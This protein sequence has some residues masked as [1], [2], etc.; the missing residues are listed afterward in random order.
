MPEGFYITCECGYE[1]YLPAANVDTEQDCINCGA[2]L[3]TR[4]TS[5][6]LEKDS[7]ALEFIAPLEETGYV[8]PD[9]RR[10]GPRSPFEDDDSLDLPREP[11]V[12]PKETPVPKDSTP[13][14]AASLFED[15][16]DDIEEQ[17]VSHRPDPSLIRNY[18][19]AE[20]KAAYQ[21]NTETDTCPQC[22]NVF[23]GDWDKQKVAGAIICYI[24]SNQATDAIP[25]RLKQDRSV[26][27]NHDTQ[28]NNWSMSVNT[29]I[30]SG[31]IEEKFW[32]FDPESENFRRMIWVLAFGMIALTIFVM[33]FTD[34]VPAPSQSSDK[35]ST[36]AGSAEE[37]S[38]PGWANAVYWAWRIFI[39]FMGQFLSIYVVLSWTDRLPHEK[40]SGNILT[41]GY[42]MFLLTLVTIVYFGLA[43]TVGE[44]MMGRVLIMMVRVIT[45]FPMIWIL[46]SV[47]DF[48]IRDFFYLIFITGFV[49]SFLNL[50]SM[51]VYA[52][53]AN[54]AL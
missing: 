24:C 8:D 4:P 5:I 46:I 35:Y 11:R 38:L 48:R 14:H 40:L 43:T 17:L 52:G 29:E 42:A 31:P 51:F 6:K 15:P 22:G 28:S 25:E 12:R 7:A 47:L 26:A 9:A 3:D 1:V 32:L 54:V 16:D 33:I 2:A 49:Y 45:G 37:V 36:T 30:P 18:H 44:S 13:D 41:I 20:H 39:V 19:G 10:S 27:P 50:I 53:L 23:R 34:S 21:G